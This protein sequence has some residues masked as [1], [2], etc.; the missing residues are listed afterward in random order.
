MSGYRTLHREDVES[1]AIWNV[2][3]SPMLISS[4]ISSQK[5]Q[6]SGQYRVWTA[7]A[8]GL[9]RSYRLREKS[10]QDKQGNDA[11]DV[12]EASAL[13]MT[14]SHVLA[15]ANGTAAGATTALGCTQVSVARNYVGED[16]AAGDLIVASLDMTGTV[17]LW[18][19]PEDEDGAAANKSNSSDP[20]KTLKA[21]HEFKVENATGTVM[22]I[23]PPR[24][25]GPG[26]DVSVA[27][28]C[29]DGTIAQVTTGW[30]TPSRL[31][32]TNSSGGDKAKQ[33]T[34]AG[35][36]IDCWG[37]R[38]Y[39]IALSI[40]SHPLAP[41]IAIGRQDGLLDT[42]P[43]TA[44]TNS[45]QYYDDQS[46]QQPQRRHRLRF[47]GNVDVPIRTVCYT[48]DGNLLAAGNDYGSIAVWDVSRGGGQQAAV[49]VHHI[50]QA[51]ANSWVLDMVALQDSR[52]WVSCGADRKLHV[53]KVDQM[54]QPVHTFDTDQT[55]WTMG[56]A[57]AA[58]TGSTSGTVTTAAATGGG[59]LEKAKRV[60]RLVAG[61]EKGGLQ[62]LSLDN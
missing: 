28:T 17:R 47:P 2:A 18:N 38:E 60:V 3:T 20:S 5:K 6:H 35:T 9:V 16:D 49:L 62:I 48:P 29:L 7:S 41:G 44:M 1:T 39:S 36:V 27:V 12:L 58:A 59:P 19:I 15:G 32:D 13:S 56:L 57:A 24:W 52:R 37:S 61:T 40:A 23:C 55:V 22:M 8:D 33:P 53:W 11:D 26:K 21:D 54:Y 42:I 31:D 46:S 30:L 4:S 25:T 34:P 14:C 45:H 10:M 43:I 50:V 51:H